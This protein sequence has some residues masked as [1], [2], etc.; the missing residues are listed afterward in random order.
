VT[1]HEIRLYAHRG[2]S[3]HLPENCVEAFAQALADGA[4]ALEL[5]VHCTRDGELV[6][7]HDPDGARTAGATER[8]QDLT[9]AQVKRWDVGNG[10]VAPDGSRP[11]AGQGHTVPTL[12]EVLEAF[13][14]V[15]MSVDLKPKRPALA[16]G[17]VELLERHGDSRRV[18][19]ASFSDRVVLAIRRLGYTG[20]TALTR[21]EIGMLRILP[22]LS[23]RLI[24]GHAAQVPLRVGPLRLDRRRFMRRCRRLGV[25]AD[26]WVVNDVAL[27]RRL[28]E[29]GATG[30]MTDDPALI[31]PVVREWVATRSP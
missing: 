17:L 7:I 15:P 21:H 1:R 2:S 4:T 25:R 13:P 12:S 26:Y 28:L 3:A 19:L 6:V 27:A 16:R 9:L 29:R 10:F 5:D 31:A 8:V 18:T 22:L 11:H 24:A 20:R 14:E 30:I 23:R